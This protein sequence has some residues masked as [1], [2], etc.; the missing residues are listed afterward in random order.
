MQR[1]LQ[2]QTISPRNTSNHPAGQHELQL[3]A[4]C[5]AEPG[6]SAGAA[7]P[8]GQEPSEAVHQQRNQGG[9]LLSFALS[10]S[11]LLPC[12]SCSADLL[13]FVPRSSR[14][15]ILTA[16]VSSTIGTMIAFS[17][18]IRMHL[19]H[20]FGLF[21]DMIGGQSLSSPVVAFLSEAV[22]LWSA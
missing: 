22:L 21:G 20:T 15:G 12:C 9:S 19:C 1:S 16:S 6:E 3:L 17:A 10:G 5:R 18:T 4:A 7:D 14:K 11:Y 2:D 13:V 8:A